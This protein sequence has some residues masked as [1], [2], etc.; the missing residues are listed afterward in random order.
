[1]REFNLPSVKIAV[2]GTKYQTESIILWVLLDLVRGVNDPINV[3]VMSNAGATVAGELDYQRAFILGS[4][5]VRLH[6]IATERMRQIEREAEANGGNI[7]S[8]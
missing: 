5:A 1:M 3:E 8:D 4:A 6:L 7:Y 2:D